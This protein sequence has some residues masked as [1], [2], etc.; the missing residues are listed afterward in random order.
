MGS[1][2]PPGKGAEMFTNTP[3]IILESIWGY[4]AQSSLTTGSTGSSSSATAS[5]ISKR[6]YSCV[7]EDSR[8]SKMFGSRP[9]RGLIIDTPG[10]AVGEAEASGDLGRHLYLLRLFET[11]V[12]R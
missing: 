2:E 7:N 9:L 6:G 4:L 8:F 3:I 11:S 1:V 10:T 5:R 12:L